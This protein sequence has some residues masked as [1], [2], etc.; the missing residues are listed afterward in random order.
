M[1]AVIQ[2]VSS[3]QVI[4]DGELTGKM[5]SAGLAILLGVRKGDT[6]EDAV[7]ACDKNCEVAHFFGRK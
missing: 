1:R 6:P 7:A 2:R 4:S 3:A 5:D